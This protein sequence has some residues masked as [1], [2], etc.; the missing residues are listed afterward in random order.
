M[1]GNFLFTKEQ[2]GLCATAEKRET[3]IFAGG[4]A[5]VS[6]GLNHADD[7]VAGRADESEVA[8]RIR[9]RRDL[10]AVEFLVVVGVDEHAPGAE[11]PFGPVLD[12]VAVGVVEDGTGDEDALG[13]AEVFSGGIETGGYADVI[14]A[15]GR[16]ADAVAGLRGN[17]H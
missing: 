5:G 3:V 1:L 16:G 10:G 6:G 15:G 2:A 8:R 12:L 14:V 17:A 4:G 13:D 7:E 9:E 11:P